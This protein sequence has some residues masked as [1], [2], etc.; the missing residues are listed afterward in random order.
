MQRAGDHLRVVA[1]G[2]LDTV[3]VMGIDVQVEHPQALLAQAHDGQRR[4][5]EKTEALGPVRHG[6][7][8]AAG[9]IECQPAGQQLFRRLHA[10]AGGRGR[11]GEEAGEVGIFQDADGV[12]LA[13]A[14]QQG[15]S[16]V[17]LEVFP[18]Q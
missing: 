9:G 18:L 16:S 7:V 2:I 5:V 13:V 1:E 6:M 4:I 14:V 17:L 12:A 8:H 3:A 10:G 11:H 15:E